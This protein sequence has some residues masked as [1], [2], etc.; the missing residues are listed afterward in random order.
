M[1]QYRK[2]TKKPT[3][4]WSVNL[5]Q[6]RQYTMKKDSL[7]IQW[8]WGN[9]TATWKRTTL[10]YCLGVPL[11]QSGLRIKHCHCNSSDWELPHASGKAKKKKKKEI[12]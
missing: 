11:W 12:L 10:E 4:L 3:R 2:H 7:F 1:E 5:G 9:Q 8:C 6:R